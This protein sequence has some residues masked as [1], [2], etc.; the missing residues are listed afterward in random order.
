MVGLG[1]KQKKERGL[2]A[3]LIGLVH[4]TAGKLASIVGLGAQK[5]NIST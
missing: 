1:M 5:K 3:D 2:A 4:P